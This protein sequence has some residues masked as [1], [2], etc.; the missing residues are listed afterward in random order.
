M[1]DVLTKSVLDPQDENRS[2]GVGKISIGVLKFY[3]ESFGPDGVDAAPSMG[4]SDMVKDSGKGPGMVDQATVG[5]TSDA[6]Q[7]C[8]KASRKI[9]AQCHNN[10]V[11]I[12][13][14]L[15]ALE[16]GIINKEE[17]KQALTHEK[18]SELSKEELNALLKLC[19][20]GQK[21]YISTNKFIDN[22]Y[23]MAAESES[24]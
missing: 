20:K 3:F 8:K 7:M 24:E 4:G 5:M 6:V 10:I 1:G 9:L 22:I 16:E 11:E 15:D 18:I 13:G 14:K 21:G 23:S 2:K 17:L 19:D 12:V